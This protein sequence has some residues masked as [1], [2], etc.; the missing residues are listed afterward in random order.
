ML[1]IQQFVYSLSLP[2]ALKEELAGDEILKHHALHLQLPTWL[3]PLFG[4]IAPE[5][6]QAL[7]FSS[8]FYFRF[9]LVVDGLL[10]EPARQGGPVSDIAA[11]RLLTYCN[12]FERSVRG[13]GTLFPADD[14]FWPAFEGCKQ[15]FAAS[16]VQEKTLSALRGEFTQ[17]AFE[18]LAAD[19]A[20]VCNGIVYA[21]R[22]LGTTSA[23]VEPLLRCLHHLHVGLQYVDDVEDFR[24]DR[25]Q[26]QYT[27][28]HAQVESYL[29][30]QHLDVHA[31]TPDQLQPFLYLS[32]TATRFYTL[33]TE[34]L[35]T[36]IA[37]AGDLGLSQ[38]T[39]LLQA[40]QAR[41]GRN[42]ATVAHFLNRTAAAA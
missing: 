41:I 30:A 40:H 39:E 21:L 15:Q 5:K 26:G 22:S 19:K 28:A 34:H 4:P 20:A 17:P 42:R 37:L 13:L 10:D 25:Q 32:G 16:N 18:Q 14:P 38:F 29:R 9:M 24:L 2:A 27:Y 3:A 33:A 31:L 1:A 6:I 8:Y 7:S 12:F 36:A 11:T 23:P 35:A